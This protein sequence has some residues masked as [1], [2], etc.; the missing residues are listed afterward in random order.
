MPHSAVIATEAR[1]RKARPARLP[2]PRCTRLRMVTIGQR[3]RGTLLFGQRSMACRIGRGGRSAHKREGDGATPAG[4]HA[5][6]FVMYRASRQR[7]PA[8]RLPISAIR[9]SDG[10]CDDPTQE[11]YN[12]PISFPFSGSA[13]RLSREDALYDIVIALGYND[14]PAKRCRGSAIFLHGLSA[15][16]TPTEGCIALCA[17]DLKRLLP[18]LRT[19]MGICC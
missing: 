8:C 10:W 14:R 13:E 3:T 6:R 7:R 16:R 1:L 4:C 12:R 2:A 5:L 9:S 18:D 11:Q 19:G 17:R 15:D